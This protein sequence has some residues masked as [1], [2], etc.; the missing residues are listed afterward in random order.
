M[1]PHSS[2]IVYVIE[3]HAQPMAPLVTEET[4]SPIPEHIFWVRCSL[5]AKLVSTFSRIHVY[6]Y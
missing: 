1:Y 2:P 3:V 6:N 4:Q 5:I